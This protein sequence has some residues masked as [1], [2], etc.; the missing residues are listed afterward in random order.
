MMKGV[1]I[2]FFFLTTA[3]AYAQ[4]EAS[5]GFA[6]NREYAW[7]LPVQ[8]A[9]DIKLANRLYT[10]PQLG[11]KYLHYYN[12]FV[13]ASLKYSILEL[14][15]TVSYEVIKKKKYIFKPNIG[16]NYRFYTIKALMDPPYNQLPQ[17]AWILDI[18]RDQPRIR[19]NSFDDDGTTHDKRK[20]NNLGFTIQLQNQFRVSEKLWIHITPFVEPDYD[21][22]QNTGGCYIGVIYKSKSAD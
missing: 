14:H 4:P 7:G 11:Y 9:F 15:Q 18:F 13:E 17:R 22:I 12:D 3:T 5:T 10:K 16:I 2:I 6:V 1:M 21:R 20:V 8:L 19:L